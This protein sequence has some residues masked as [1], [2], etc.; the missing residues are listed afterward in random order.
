MIVS[1]LTLIGWA[2]LVASWVIPYM[3]RKQAS[4]FADRQKS[5]SVGMLL[6]AIALVIFVSNGIMHCIK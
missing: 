6:A 4:T 2:F 1:T 3:M 5:Y